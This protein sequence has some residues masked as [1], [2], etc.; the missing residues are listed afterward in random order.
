[1]S[2]RG[3]PHGIGEITFRSEG[4]GPIQFLYI[5]QF[6]KTLFDGIGQLF[7]PDGSNDIAQW[8][9]LEYDGL[10]QAYSASHRL[11]R[12]RYSKGAQYGTSVHRSKDVEHVFTWRDGMEDGFSLHVDHGSTSLNVWRKGE[13]AAT[14]LIGESLAKQ[15][16][17][18]TC[19][20]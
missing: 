19:A 16:A 11:T 13:L 3:S 2:E 15:Y 17:C 10:R 4:S 9:Q 14:S 20:L 8:R 12:A 18:R 6:N 5:G 7:R 1:V